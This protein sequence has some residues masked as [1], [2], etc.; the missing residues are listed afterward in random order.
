MPGS[1]LVLSAGRSAEAA[2]VLGERFTRFGVASDRVELVYRLPAGEYLEAYQPIDLGLDPFPYNGG[3]TTCDALWMG[4]PVLSVAGRDARSRRGVSV[5]TNLGLPE[6]VADSPEKLVE[7][8]AT[9]ADQR[10]GVSELRGT[11]REMMRQSPVTDGAR[12]ARH[13]EAAYRDLWKA[14]L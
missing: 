14:I 6:F 8:A 3:V 10:P 4:L 9:W 5:L 2:R 13:L 12:V 11:L 7:L 1:R